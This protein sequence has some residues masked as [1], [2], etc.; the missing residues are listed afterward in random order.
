MIHPIIHLLAGGPLATF[1]IE[2]QIGPCS[3]ELFR[4]KRAG[5]L[6]LTMPPPGSVVRRWAVIND[7]TPA[8]AR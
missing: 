6:W 5:I 8:W 7:E 1:Q 3:D 4:L 2:G